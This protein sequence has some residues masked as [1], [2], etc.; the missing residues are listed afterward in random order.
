[1]RS[2]CATR[3]N[4]SATVALFNKRYTRTSEMSNLNSQLYEIIVQ[5][6]A[7]SRKPD[8]FRA[9]QTFRSYLLTMGSADEKG[10]KP[11][12]TTGCP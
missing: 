8:T 9:N 11:V 1:M 12:S 5:Q 3:Y 2:F 6:I 7:A 10:V 4:Q